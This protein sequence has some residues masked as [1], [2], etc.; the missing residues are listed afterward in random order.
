MLAMLA[1]MAALVGSTPP[2]HCLF[3]IGDHEVEPEDPSIAVDQCYPSPDARFIV[4]VR[5]G[6]ITVISA[7]GAFPAG[8]MDGGRILWSPTSRGFAVAD[9]EGSGETEVFRY[10]DVMLPR[11]KVNLSLRRT[12]IARF[13]AVYGCHGAGAYA[14]T[15]TAGWTSRG[16]VRLVVQDG[17]HSEGCYRGH[18]DTPMIG[19]IGNPVTGHILRQLSA[20]DIGREWCTEA[21]RAQY[22][23][24]YDEAAFVA[25]H[26]KQS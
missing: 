2:Q 21:Q 23:Y 3:D 1:I 6:R 15:I 19:V 5:D 4:K 9:S 20:A 11:P 7:R 18:G 12:A 13:K 16:Y 8:T 22:G 24:C 26:K 17:V 14:N 25:A 10:V